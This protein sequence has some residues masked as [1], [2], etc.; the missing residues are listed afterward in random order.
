M[1]TYASKSTAVRG[2]KRA[3][4]EHYTI[5]P[6]KDGR[7]KI[8][9]TTNNLEIEAAKEAVAF[10]KANDFVSRA[11]AEDVSPAIEVTIT[12]AE[13]KDEIIPLHFIVRPQTPSLWEDETK[14]LA[15][16][17]KKGAAA[18]TLDRATS[19]LY[20]Y[21]LRKRSSIEGAVG[22]TWDIASELQAELDDTTACPARKDVLEACE[23]AGIATNTARTQYQAWRKANNFVK[24]K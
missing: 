6:Q 15:S 2:A 9:G 8:V 11:Y 23:A 5:E 17:N 21:N 13:L 16:Q 12:L 18:I 24:S 4:I 7:F 1:K 10:M 14:V 22:H 3:G 20:N 19:P